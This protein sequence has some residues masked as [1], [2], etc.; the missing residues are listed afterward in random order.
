[1]IQKFQRA[2]YR[3]KVWQKSIDLIEFVYRSVRDFPREEIYGLTSQIKRSA[4][5]IPLNIAEGCG[6]ESTKEKK[7]FFVM[8]RGSLVEL[9]TQ[10]IIAVRL[11]FMNPETHDRFLDRLNEISAMLSGLISAVLRR[12]SN[13]G[14]A[15]PFSDSDAISLRSFAT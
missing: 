9:E 11:G 2:H 1:M 3:L 14:L 5:S 6:R 12:T 10:S 4:I 15:T 7:R 8:A 13:D